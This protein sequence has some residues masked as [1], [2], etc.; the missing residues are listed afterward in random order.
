MTRI[1]RRG[2]LISPFAVPLASTGARAQTYPSR[3]V[4]ILVGGAAGSVPDTVARIVGDRLATRLGE[5]VVIE[6]RPGA[7]GNIAMKALASERAR[8]AQCLHSQRCHRRCS[9]PTYSPVR[10]M[11]HFVISPRCPR[12]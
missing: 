10:V 7:A 4:H 6:N 11:I 12:S 9:T 1:T 2:V 3:A 5:S 8:W